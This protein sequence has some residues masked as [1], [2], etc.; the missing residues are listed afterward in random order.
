MHAREQENEF[1]A[2]AARAL[3]QVRPSFRDELQEALARQD[4]GGRWLRTLFILSCLPGI[5]NGAHLASYVFLADDSEHWCAVPELSQSGWSVQQIR[6]ISL[7]FAEAQAQ[8]ASEPLPEE[9]S[10]H[11]YMFLEA[12]RD[13]SIV[14][15]WSLVCDNA[16]LRSTAQVALA[17]GKIIG[18]LLF[19]C[20]SDR[21]GRKTSFVAAALVY[22]V[23]G[24]AAA[25]SYHFTVFLCFRVALGAAGAGTFFTAYTI[26]AESAHP[27]KRPS[28]GVLFNIS[29]P[30]G[31]LA[32][33]VLALIMPSWRALQLAISL[34]ALIL[35]LPS[36][37]LPESP[38][39]LLVQGRITEALHVLRHSGSRKDSS[40]RLSI[41]GA[42]DDEPEQEHAACWVGSGAFLR[43]VFNLFRKSEFRR[44]LVVLQACWFACALTYHSL[45]LSGATLLQQPHRYVAL[46][47]AAELLG[48]LVPPLLLR[49]MGRRAAS[50]MLLLC[51]AAALLSLLAIPPEWKSGVLAAALIGRLCVSAAYSVVALYTAELFPTVARGTAI[52]TCTT[53]AQF[54]SISAPYI[55]D[56][57]GSQ[58]AH[59]PSTI[60]GAVAAFA[61]IVILALPETRDLPLVETIDDVEITS[62]CENCTS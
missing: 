19:G 25:F 14:S 23:A 44:R 11:S 58:S 41:L 18:S 47:G 50:S 16:P 57:L 20:I 26:L 53:V 42:T 21:M 48:Y 52:G 30:I 10:C 15:E 5:L 39:W 49:S 17:V 13:A 31:I 43:R 54:A 32:L 60:C 36:W 1:A 34:P 28:L 3:Q 55:V 8:L 33:P 24:P 4:N 29:Y 9:R 59:I 37:F 61:S 51:T 12:A 38:R 22:L 6:N 2:S 40:R 27:L 35:V 45:A 46:L 7:S 62:R 56:I